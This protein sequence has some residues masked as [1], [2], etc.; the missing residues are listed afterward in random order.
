[1]Q[2]RRVI[3][4]TIISL[5]PLMIP[6]IGMQFSSE[7]TWTLSDFVVAWALLLGTTLGCDL[8]LRKVKNLKHRIAICV[9]LLA[10]LL[11]IWAE[12]AVGILG[13]P[14]SGS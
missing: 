11:L 1:M 3:I 4:I 8:T 12:L 9:A 10:L 5:T 2:Y 13:T 7:V 6:L 14:F